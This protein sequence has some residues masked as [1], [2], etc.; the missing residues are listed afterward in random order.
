MQSACRRQEMMWFGSPPTWELYCFQVFSS[1]SCLPLTRCPFT[2]IPFPQ[3]KL[4][5]GILEEVEYY[6][7][8]DGND[9]SQRLESEQVRSMS[10][11]VSAYWEVD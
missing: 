8:L 5:E 2:S 3:M 7:E 9:T 6:T 11:R 1:T 4:G 10:G